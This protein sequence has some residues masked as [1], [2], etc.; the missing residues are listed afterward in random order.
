ME[1]KFAKG[2]KEYLVSVS[3]CDGSYYHGFVFSV[4]LH[5]RPKG[6]R[7]W[8]PF[9]DI[10]N[11]RYRQMGYN[12]RDK[13]REELITNEIPIEWIDEV[14]QMEIENISKSEYKF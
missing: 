8:I 13:Q 4:D 3:L 11:Y 6:K 1:K 10:N 5:T 12:E 2:E 14:K 9:I 7:K